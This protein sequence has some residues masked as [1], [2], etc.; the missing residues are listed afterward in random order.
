M[1]INAVSRLKAD[2]N[3]KVIVVDGFH[4][5]PGS[6]T[7]KCHSPKDAYKQ[8]FDAIDQLEHDGWKHIQGANSKKMDMY[9][10]GSD[11]VS[12]SVHN[13]MLNIDLW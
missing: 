1:K 2:A 6:N 3:R 5:T 11:E 12:V 13:G 8:A 7:F 10:K 9:K 4:I